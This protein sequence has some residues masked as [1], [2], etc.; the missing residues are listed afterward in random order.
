L[1]SQVYLILDEFICG[2][3][4]QETAKKVRGQSA[5][6]TLTLLCNET[7]TVACRARAPLHQGVHSCEPVVT[8]PALGPWTNTM[9]GHAQ[10]QV[11]LERLSELD[12]IIT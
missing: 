12:K 7:P 9:H 2:G 11:I 1:N 5:A 6:C 10:P 8:Y 3:E 4:I